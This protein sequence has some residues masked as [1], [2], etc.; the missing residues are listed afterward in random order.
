V[1]AR[2]QLLPVALFAAFYPA[3][4]AAVPVL[5]TR[6]RRTLLLIVFLAGGL[7]ASIGL[8]LV[9]VLVLRTAL[10]RRGGAQLGSTMDLVVGCVVLA[11][12]IALARHADVRVARLRKRDSTPNRPAELRRSLAQRIL[13][14]A[15]V[16]AVLLLSLA[17]NVP[18]PAYL[19]GLKDIAA[20]HDDTTATIALV[21]AFNLVMFLLAEVPLVGL[22]VD[23]ARTEGVVLT[24][25]GWLNAHGRRIAIGLCLALS[26]FLIVRG[27]TRG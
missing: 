13:E 19:V 12:A 9:F 8:G 26:S 6:P 23:P 18:G 27:I 17:M 24:F 16:P 2:L 14:R 1:A 21:I 10:H 7:S 4:L 11:L 20:A 22:I 15:E 3:L 5:L 25:N